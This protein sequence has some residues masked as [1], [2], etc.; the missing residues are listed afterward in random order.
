MDLLPGLWLALLGLLLARLLRRWYDPL[1]PRVWA[2]FAILLLAFYG[3]V[4]FGGKLL[5][6]LDSLRGST[7]FGE[8]QPTVPHGNLIQG[9]LIQLIAPSRELVREAVAQ[10]RW[11]LWNPLSGAGLPLLADPQAQVLQPL[12]TLALPFSTVQGAR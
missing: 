8:L 3:P 4:L 6:P 1:P 9:D 12:A 2:L 10:G 11:P 7:P 5:L